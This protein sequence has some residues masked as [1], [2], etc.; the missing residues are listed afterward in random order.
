MASK[1][2]QRTV[3]AVVKIPLDAKHHTY[4]QILP[5]AD[6]AVFDSRSVEDLPPTEVISRP[7]LFRLA[8]YNH[9]ITRGRWLKVGAAPLRDEFQ[10]PAVKFIQDPIKPTGETRRASR[11][12]CNGLERCAVWEPEHV[13]DRIRDHY[14]GV[15]NKWLQSL[16]IR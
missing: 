2:Q 13:E 10:K 8:V 4:G 1:R 5:E 6:L 14:R 15:P 16:Q 9:A 3:G 11:A 7:V 12:D